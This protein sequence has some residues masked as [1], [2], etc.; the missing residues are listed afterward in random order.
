MPT[1]ILLCSLVFFTVNLTC[2]QF[3]AGLAMFATV[4]LG[5]IFQDYLSVDKTY[6][7]HSPAVSQ[8]YTGPHLADSWAFA[9]VTTVLASGVV[10]FGCCS[11]VLSKKT[12]L[13]EYSSQRSKASKIIATALC[14]MFLVIAVLNTHWIIS[15]NETFKE[16]PV[17]A[18]VG[19]YEVCPWYAL[20]FYLTHIKLPVSLLNFLMWRLFLTK[21]MDIKKF[22]F[23]CVD[24]MKMPS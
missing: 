17:R 23:F 12:E 13:Q 6:L 22:L 2:A 7:P 4:A 10:F 15:P 3:L 8:K 16:F 11:R 20:H 21:Y 1:T 9:L 19:L 18:E 14:S 5:W 24:I